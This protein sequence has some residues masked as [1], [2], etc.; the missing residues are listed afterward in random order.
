M[1]QKRATWR[2]WETGLV[3]MAML[4]VSH[5]DLGHAQRLRRSD[6][7]HITAVPSH[8]S[9][10]TPQIH[11]DRSSQVVLVDRTVPWRDAGRIVPALSDACARRQFR[12]RRPLRFRAVYQNAI[13]GMAFGHGLNL[14][15]PEQRADPLMMYLFVN[16]GTSGCTVLVRPNPDARVANL[17]GQK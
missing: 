11:R 3:V 9:Y 2:R 14:Y 10:M 16:G 7:D 6:R 1:T 17:F 4:L 15:D 5:T 8:R 13:L 12:E